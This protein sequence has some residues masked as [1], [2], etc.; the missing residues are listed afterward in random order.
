[1][2]YINLP[3]STKLDSFIAKY[4]LTDKIKNGKIL[5]LNINKI[6]WSHKL[7]VGTTNIATTSLVEEI[8]IFEIV[9][10]SK[11]IPKKAIIEIDKLIPYPILYKF[12]YKDEFCYGISLLDKKHSFFSQW[13]DSIEFD[14]S[15][16]TLEQVYENIVKKFLKNIDSS[17]NLS[18]NIEKNER[19]LVLQKEID[20]LNNKIKKERQFKK[21][22]ELSRQ[23]K[24]K[25]KELKDLTKGI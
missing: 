17:M 9:L 3:K 18:Q 5:F 1:M 14:F 22:L 2:T 11:E 4:K 7:S 12:I 20:S 21:Q 6:T 25:E 15:A 16:S 19:M 8:H 10:K 13:G 23:V 24:P